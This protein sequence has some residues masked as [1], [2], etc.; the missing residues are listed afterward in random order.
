MI[1]QYLFENLYPK[2]IVLKNTFWLW[3]G[4]I[5][6]KLCKLILILF[7][8]RILGP[9][10]YG[11]FSYALAFL[12]IFFVFSDWGVSNILIR[13][14]QQKED[15]K[16]IIDVGFTTKI[17]LLVLISVI[18]ILSFFFL[19]D[20]EAKKIYFILLIF[21]FIDNIKIYFSAIFNALQRMEKPAFI[22]FVESLATLILA[23]LLLIKIK[24]IVSLALAYLFGAILAFI[25]SKQF[26]NLL[27]IKINFDVNPE[28]IKYFLINGTPLML[29]GVLG[30]IF[31]TT[32]Q[33]L[34]GYFRTMEEVGYYSV[35]SK[36]ILN[37]N[38]F[39]SLFLTALF[40]YLASKVND[41][42]KIR[43]ITK[44]VLLIL[45]SSA[46]LIS[47]ILYFLAPYIVP[48]FLGSKYYQSINVL[49]YLIWIIVF[50]FPTMFFDNILFAFNKQWQDFGITSFAAILNLLLNIF[51]IPI[52]G[53]YGAIF[54]SILAQI[55]N[56]VL[57]YALVYKTINK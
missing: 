54:S 18:S 13:D 53:M 34:L 44:K 4:N 16:N 48:L 32:D 19:K 15:K 51:T 24:S 8:A 28:K 10:I 20:P 55:V 12:G 26:I 39:P 46:I 2:Q 1:Q 41:I 50:L 43:E 57:S 7:S 30:Y 6:G 3:L 56:F 21:L 22:E 36:L 25:I 31:F 11:S 17:F 47:L 5:L 37:I 49:R 45:I 52:Y 14:Y 23:I 42:L 29:F 40:P 27:N 35:I 38:I 33:L 9:S